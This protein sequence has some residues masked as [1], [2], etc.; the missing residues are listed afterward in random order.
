MIDLP[1]DIIQDLIISN[2][3]YFRA[4]LGPQKKRRIKERDIISKGKTHKTVEPKEACEM[5]EASVED[6]YTPE[7]KR[8]AFSRVKKKKLP[9][10]PKKYASLVETCISY[11]TP[12]KR[13][14]LSETFL[15]PSKRKRLFRRKHEFLETKP[16]YSKTIKEV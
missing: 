12:R 1:K 7:A 5:N 4:K 8:K 11:G 10:E 6:D 2:F 16:Q 15:T 14:L 3:L 13:K 9:S